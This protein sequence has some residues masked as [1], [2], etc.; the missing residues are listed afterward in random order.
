MLWDHIKI[1]FMVRKIEEQNNIVMQRTSSL[2]N[3]IAASL[4]TCRLPLL[5]PQ[6]THTVLN[7]L[8][9]YPS[10]IQNRCFLCGF[11]NSNE[12]HSLKKKIAR[13][14]RVWR[15]YIYTIYIYIVLCFYFNGV[16]FRATYEEKPETFF[17]GMILNRACKRNHR[18]DGDSFF[19]S[20]A[21]P[22]QNML[23]FLFQSY[24][25]LSAL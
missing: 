21:R 2:P 17:E 23:L 18:W 8:L 6:K 10:S 3:W 1:H 20:K 11:F 22:P 12:N 7:L 13:L 4:K 24:V 5:L 25:F 9:G 14:N 16:T 19:V 15:L